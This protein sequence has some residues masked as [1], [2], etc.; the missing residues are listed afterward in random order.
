MVAGCSNTQHVFRNTYGK[1]GSRN[2]APF[3]YTSNSVYYI[4]VDAFYTVCDMHLRRHAIENTVPNLKKRVYGRY[5]RI[6]VRSEGVLGAS[7]PTVY[8]T[9]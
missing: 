5:E 8:Y 9:V 7:D 2:G 6:L 1:P 3:L 4:Y